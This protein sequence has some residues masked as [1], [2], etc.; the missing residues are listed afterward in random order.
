MPVRYMQHSY[1][2]PPET[3]DLCTDVGPSTDESD[4]MTLSP[5]P[6]ATEASSVESNCQHEQDGG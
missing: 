1:H 2:I 5:S 6:D 3:E 4:K